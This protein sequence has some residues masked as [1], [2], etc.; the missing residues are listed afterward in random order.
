M[1]PQARITFISTISRAT[2]VDQSA[3]RSREASIDSIR[4]R[5]GDI[6]GRHVAAKSRR[7]A[8]QTPV[9]PGRARARLRKRSLVNRSARM[10]PSCAHLAEIWGNPIR[11]SFRRPAS[12]L[13]T[14]ARKRPPADIGA[15]EAFGPVDRRDAAIGPLACLR[16]IRTEPCHGEHAPAMGG[17]CA[18]AVT[19][20]GME[21]EGIGQRTRRIDATN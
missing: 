18:G 12:R 16:H 17:E 15:A 8:R 2:C 10:P 11:M 7:N 14:V 1:P 5:Y 20:T 9:F 3:F 21:D 6:A 13:V 19:R 4:V